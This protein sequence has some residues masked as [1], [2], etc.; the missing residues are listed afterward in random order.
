MTAEQSRGPGFPRWLRFV[1]GAAVV[2]V[3]F[4]FLGSRLVR[5]W[6]EIPF[7]ELRFHP[8]PL[9]G[10][11]AIFIFLHFPLY[12]WAWRFILAG[13]GERLPFFRAT[14]ILAVTQLG[15][16]IPGKVW[17]TLGRMSLCKREGIPEAKT[18]VSVIVEIVLALLAALLLLGLAVLFVPRSS[19]PSSL[20]LLF[21]L[22]PVCL[23]AVFPPVLNR[24][25]KLVLPW[26]RRP[27]FKLELS[28]LRMLLITGMY[29]ADWALQGI[30]SWLLINS[31]YPV[32]ASQLPVLLGGYAVSW[33]IGF[34]LLVAPAGLGIREGVLTLILKMV[35]PVP[36]AIIAAGLT[37]MWITVAEAGMA[38]AGLP[39]VARWRKNVQ[40]E[41]ISAGSGS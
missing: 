25:L 41:E 5:D 12:G 38:L 26:F 7:G 30:G 22:V 19:I 39:F 24:L 37:R 14:V 9:V 23:I 17:F 29:L 8:L 18:M 31:F 2:A 16:Y 6:Q 11:F 4:Y 40:E 21:A 36:L 32:S 34:L 35:M 27:V 33:M 15:K 10:S 28:Y 20:Y 3:S 1:L 13:L